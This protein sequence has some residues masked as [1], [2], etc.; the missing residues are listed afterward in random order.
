VDD[1]HLHKDY[2][3]K[4]KACGLTSMI[5]LPIIINDHVEGA[6]ELYDWMR[7]QPYTKDELISA[8]KAL[9]NF[10]AELPAGASWANE[11]YLKALTSILRSESSVNWCTYL[12]VSEAGLPQVIFEAGQT[13]WMMGQ[14]QAVTV[15]KDSLY[16]AALHD[17]IPFSVQLD[18]P[19][20]S[21][22]DRAL[23]PQMENGSMMIVPLISRGESVG[24][25]IMLDVNPERSFSMSDLSLGQAIANVTGHAVANARMYG[26]LSRRAKQ[27]ETAYYQLRVADRIKDEVIQNVSHELRTPLTLIMGYTELLSAQDLGPLSEDQQGAVHLISDKSQQL[28]RL[29]E[30]ILSVQLVESEQLS[31]QPASLV[32]MADIALLAYRE[33]AKQAGIDLITQFPMGLPPISVNQSRITQSIECLVS[34]AIK[35]SPKDSTVIISISDI[36]PALEVKVVD[37]GI[38]IP[39]EEHDRVWWSFYQVDG[40]TTRQYG[41]TGI[42]LTIVK[43]AVEAHG[44]RVWLNSA[45]G[46]GSTF[47]FVLPKDR[48]A[49]A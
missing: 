13:Q 1:E 36:G 30:D 48:P 28:A 8:Y 18:D 35:F 45:P 3:K 26:E 43:N 29:V 4:L 22:A 32:E 19:A 27:L 10:L 9:K 46:R 25:I 39:E 31:R 12:K 14:G 40:S 11:R 5:V 7:V 34:N 21:D 37:E 2:L 17:Q 38:G 23:L 20:I 42:G 47:G 16:A 15:G 44:G 49:T 24:L 6:V 33:Q 41:G